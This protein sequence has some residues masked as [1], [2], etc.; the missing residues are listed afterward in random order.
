MKKIAIIIGSLSDLSQCD[1]GLKFLS[2]VP[3]SE[4]EV[5]GVFIRSQHRNTI[6]TQSLLEK[7]TKEK[8]DVI[9]VGAGWAN[10]LTGCCDAYL[11]YQLQ[12]DH[13]VVVGVAFDDPKN[14][15]HT[16]AAIL[17]ITEVP[18]T[19]VLFGDE[20]GPF[21]GHEGFLEACIKATEDNLPKIVI[22]E[23]KLTMD[24]SLQEAL[25]R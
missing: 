2:S 14:H 7:L 15:K 10:H 11:R 17:S 8:T 9:I 5:T 13:T 22:P 23:P 19:Q 6:S 25:G 24:L 12:N 18:G 1:K 16:E 20:S 4:V 3:K 21:V